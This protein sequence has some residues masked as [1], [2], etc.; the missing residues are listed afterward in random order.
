MKST[1]LLLL[2]AIPKIKDDVLYA[3]SKDSMDTQYSL[4]KDLEFTITADEESIGSPHKFECSID[5][6][7]TISIA[8]KCL[9]VQVHIDKWR[10]WS[11]P[12]S[13]RHIIKGER[14]V[15]LVL[16]DYDIENHEVVLTP[17]CR[18]TDSLVRE[19]RI[20]YEGVMDH[21]RLMRELNTTTI[22]IDMISFTLSD[23]QSI[24]AQITAITHATNTANPTIYTIS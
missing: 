16:L 13:T 7:T 8:M 19:Y 15:Q 23:L 9:P 21:L 18:T 4:G 2:E 5:S 17:P 11:Y 3:I 24:F 14:E 1:K 12:D 6:S 10:E 20:S 22:M